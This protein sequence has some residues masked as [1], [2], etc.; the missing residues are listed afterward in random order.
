MIN[1][2]TRDGF[3]DALLENGHLKNI[4]VLDADLSSATRT[5]KFAEKYPNKFIQCGISEM[6]M[7]G[8]ASGLAEHGFVPI[9]TSFGAFIT[10]RYD[11][12][13][14]SLA[15]SN[16]PVIVVGTHAGMAIGKD[17][18]TQMGLEDINLM[19]G[20][21]NMEIYQPST[22]EQAKQITKFLLIRP[23][24]KLSYL[25]LSRRETIEIEENLLE[26][27]PYQFQ[28]L[29]TSNSDIILFHSGCLLEL[30][31]SLSLAKNYELVNVPTI[32]PIKNSLFDIVKNKKLIVTIEDHS[33]IG[34]IGS[35]ICELVAENPLILAKVLRIGLNDVFPESGDP[36]DLYNKYGLSID[37]I[38]EKIKNAYK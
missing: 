14:C 1:K 30:C 13:R 19:R 24:P 35:M 3:G 20:L 18:V 12:I 15:Y 17:G 22:Y 34:G 21:P 36:K 27:N 11:Q 6:N 37:S 25:R 4:I 31:F 16:A 8:I 26:F 33:I 10:G 5:S 38:K 32:K 2:S 28:K 9:I 23:E 7:I 29:Y